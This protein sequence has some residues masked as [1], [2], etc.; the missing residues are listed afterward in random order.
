VLEHLLPA[1]PQY[2]AQ[3][4]PVLFLFREEIDRPATLHSLMRRARARLLR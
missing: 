1:L 2:L 4:S 3:Q